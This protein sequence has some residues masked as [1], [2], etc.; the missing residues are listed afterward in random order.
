MPGDNITYGADY[1]SATEGIDGNS[2]THSYEYVSSKPA[3]QEEVYSYA[4]TANKGSGQNGSSYAYVGNDR[5]SG[6]P[7]V[8]PVQYETLR[9]ARQA[10]VED[11]EGSLQDPSVHYEFSTELTI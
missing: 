4:E 6:T 5:R 1:V 11:R 9:Q 2:N 10:A 8:P 3:P 7:A